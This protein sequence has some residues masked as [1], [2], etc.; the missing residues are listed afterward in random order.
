MWQAKFS[1]DFIPSLVNKSL[2]LH[3]LIFTPRQLSGHC[4]PEITPS[5]SIAFLHLSFFFN[6]LVWQGCS[7]EEFNVHET[8]R[9][10]QQLQLRLSSHRNFSLWP[11][12]PLMLGWFLLLFLSNVFATIDVLKIWTI[13]RINFYLSQTQSCCPGTSAYIDYLESNYH[14]YSSNYAVCF[15]QNSL[16][17]TDTAP[18]LK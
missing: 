8:F 2:K 18:T 15:F 13:K 6:I 9:V 3:L 10:L 14:V 11:L 5:P 7:Q 12:P 1:S 17:W 16:M 4:F